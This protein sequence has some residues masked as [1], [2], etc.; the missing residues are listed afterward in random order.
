MKDLIS[1]KYKHLLYR[2]E[3]SELTDFLILNYAEVYI[4]SKTELCVWCWSPSKASWLRKNLEIT[5][6]WSTDDNLYLLRVPIDKLDV[7]IQ[8]GAPK[9][10]IHRKGKK[11]KHL[12]ERLGHKI[13]PFRPGLV[14]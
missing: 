4:Y 12:E 9:R 1:K 8:L 14:Q 5:F 7:L 3:N 11:L 10:R 2:D 13:L 6:D